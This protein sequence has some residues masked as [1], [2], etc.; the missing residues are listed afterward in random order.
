MAAVKTGLDINVNQLETH[1]MAGGKHRPAWCK[2]LYSAARAGLPLTFEVP[3]LLIWRN[4]LEAVQMSVNPKVIR[5]KT[6]S[7]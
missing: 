6:V 3:P 1:Y 7:S 4:P 2:R 5:T